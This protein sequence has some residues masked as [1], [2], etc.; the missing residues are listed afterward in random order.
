M[1]KKLNWRATGPDDALIEDKMICPPA[2]GHCT[3][4]VTGP[5]TMIE[6]SYGVT[7]VLH[8]ECVKAFKGEIKRMWAEQ[9]IG[10]PG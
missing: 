8:P 3:G 7:L 10:I 5:R 6:T 9:Y 1:K 4:Y 2:C